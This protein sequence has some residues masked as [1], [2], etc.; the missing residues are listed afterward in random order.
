VVWGITQERRGKRLKNRADT[1]L[2]ISRNIGVKMDV[3]LRMLQYK[4]VNVRPMISAIMPLA[5]TQR[6][7]DSMYSREN[8]AVLLKT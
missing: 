5:E 2:I 1:I 3:T 6:G 8:I 7:F 4:R